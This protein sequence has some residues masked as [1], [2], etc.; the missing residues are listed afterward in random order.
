MSNY[1][2]PEIAQRFWRYV[3]VR[4]ADECWPWLG[5]K[6]SD[7]YG[8]FHACLG[9]TVTAH[10]WI[11]EYQIGEQ[12]TRKLDA[13][14][15]CSG[16]HSRCCCNPK[17]IVFETRKANIARSRRK[18]RNANR[19]LSDQQCRELLAAF[20]EQGHR[21]GLAKRFGVTRHVVYNV[22]CGLYYRDATG[23]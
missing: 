22:T 18:R 7:G 5:G 10:R 3:D 16:P 11:A 23:L 9:Y 17:H 14:H 8:I 20:R 21:R 13:S 4:D 15:T 6:T 12:V 2:T 19:L 1:F